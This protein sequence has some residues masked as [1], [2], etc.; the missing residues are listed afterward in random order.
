MHWLFALIA[1]AAFALYW[2][3]SFILQA[4]DATTHFGADS[5]YY[6]ELAKPDIFGRLNWDRGPEELRGKGGAYYLDR[7]ARFHP[8]T[9]FLAAGWMKMLAPF[10]AWFTPLQ[11]L[12]AMFA[13]VGALGVWAA[14]WGVT[15]VLPRRYGMLCGAIYGLSLGVW[16]FASIEESKIIT[17]TLCTLYIAV[18]LHLRARWTLSRAVLLT[19]ILLLACLN[20]MVSGL[21]VVIPLIDT[22]LMHGLHWHALRWLS[23]HMLAGP[24][25][26]LLIEGGMYGRLVGQSHPEGGS[27]LGMLFTYIAKNTYTWQKLY[28]FITNWLFFNIAAPTPHANV[29]VP[30]GA[31]YK[32]YFE[33]SLLNYLTSPISLIIALLVALIM[34]ALVLPRWRGPLLIPHPAALLLAFGGY[35]LARALFFVVF[36]PSEPLL[37]SPAVTL[38]HVLIVGLPFAG[39]QLPYKKTILT[40]IAVLLLVNNGRFMLGL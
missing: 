18:Y 29:G 17:A 19:V 39:S 3:S 14:M 8:L 36:N 40:A 4:R 20:E 15:A 10:T 6:A 16:Y 7:V 2:G 22:A 28:G 38:A 1:C 34:L 5:W 35:T 23:A 11:L 30:P 25:A 9:V 13:A 21:L 24:L 33:R 27:H 31:T 37:F 12:K 26:F 32:G